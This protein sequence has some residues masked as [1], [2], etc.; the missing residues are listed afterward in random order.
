MRRGDGFHA[1]T[2][3][4]GEE[5]GSCRLPFFRLLEFFAASGLLVSRED[6]KTRKMRQAHLFPSAHARDRD[7]RANFEIRWSS[8][9]PSRLRVRQNTARKEPH[10]KTRRREEGGGGPALHQPRRSRR[11]GVKKFPSHSRLGE[12][13]TETPD[14]EGEQ[15]HAE[16]RSSPSRTGRDG[17]RCSPSRLCSL[18]GWVSG[19]KAAAGSGF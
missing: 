12:E 7:S 16:T 5:A 9:R 11:L 8:S 13:S 17:W 6:A 4:R 10:A 18:L 3:R 15:V 19:L 1:E 14:G 2:R